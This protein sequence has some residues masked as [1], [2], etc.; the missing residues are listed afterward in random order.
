ME[1]LAFVFVGPSVVAVSLLND[2][3]EA[4]VIKH[5]QSTRVVVAQVAV[6]VETGRAREGGCVNV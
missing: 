3:C 1:H 4:E 6:V 2:S 5:F